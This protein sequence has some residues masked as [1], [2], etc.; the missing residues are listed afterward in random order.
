MSA[1]AA[2]L[3]AV[4]AVV[5]DLDGVLV[6]SEEMWDEVRR[7]LAAKAGRPWPA[8]ATRAMQGMSTPEW[9]NYLAATVG[10]PVPAPEL[11][12]TVIN[13]MAAR[14]TTNLPLLPGAREA[15]ERIAARW[16]LGLASS[17]P[18]RIIDAVLAAAGI[19]HRFHS[20][21]S[22]EEVAAGKPSPL[23][24]L[25]AVQRLGVSPARTVAIEDS[26]N[27]LR[28]AAAGGLVVLAVPNPAFPPAPDALDLA[29]ATVDRLSAIT[30]EL[31]A[32]LIGQ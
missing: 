18:R 17:S 24:Y 21:V 6:D 3:S 26:T 28:S 23:V 1:G 30:P 29:T 14:Y 25:T 22:T 19:A 4:E 31:I 32:S 27:G 13:T 11:A 7:G 15:V 8:E 9:S 12:E 16:P 10:I 5:F 2:P 20:T